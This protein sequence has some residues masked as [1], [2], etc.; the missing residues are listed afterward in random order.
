MEIGIP[1]YNPIVN[2][3]S[4]KLLY[5]LGCD[6][7][8]PEEIP[9]D[10]K[11]I[12]QGTHG[13]QG[14]NRADLILPGATYL[15]KSATYVSTEGR[16]NVTRVTAVPPYLAREDWEIIRALSETLGCS[17]P[18]DEVYDLRNRIAELAPHLL[19]YDHLEPHGYENLM[20]DLHNNDNIKVN[21][22]NLTDAV[23]NFYMTDAISRASPVMAKCSHAFNKKRLRNFKNLFVN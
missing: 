13:D 10:A 11:V 14:A 15:E 5:I 2:N 19:K 6:D 3:S 8:L 12:Y 23:D 4:P 21:I 17:L 9:Q 22:N 7:Y 18:Y 20:L 16:V 1:L